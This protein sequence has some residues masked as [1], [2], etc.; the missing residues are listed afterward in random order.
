MYLGLLGKDGGP[1]DA[2][3]AARQHGDHKHVQDHA[4]REDAALVL[5]GAVGDLLL[6][7]LLLQV[8][9]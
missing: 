8:R 3:E 4:Q 6:D 5:A 2:V 9:L 7:A 1:V